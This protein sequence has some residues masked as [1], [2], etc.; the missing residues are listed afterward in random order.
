[1]NT[2]LEHA[3]KLIDLV[4]LKESVS[5][6]GVVRVDVDSFTIC[7]AFIDDVCI[8]FWVEDENAEWLEDGIECDPQAAV[9][10]IA[11]LVARLTA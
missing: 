7:A 9:K 4:L 1:M 2:A 5:P 6:G 11:S 3:S 10:S 8:E